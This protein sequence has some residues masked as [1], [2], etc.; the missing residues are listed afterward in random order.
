[1]EQ[2]PTTERTV[3]PVPAAILTLLVAGTNLAAQELQ[4]P[5]PFATPSTRNSASIIV[6]PEGASLRVPSGFAIE[7]YADNLPG[8]RTML[9]TPNGDILIAQRGPGTVTILRDTDGNRLPD[10]RY[11]YINDLPGVF[12]MAFH[13]GY[14]Y[15]GAN[16][17][18][19]RVPYEP[20]DTA[21]RGEP[22]HIVDMPTGGHSTRN[23]IF[24]R[25][26]TRMYVAVGSVSNK[27]AGEDEIRAA[28]S[29]YNPD[30]TG[31]RIYA[32]GLRNP[33]GLALQPGTNT[34]WT[35]VNERDT[36][37]DDL[38]PDYITSVRDGGFYGWPYSYI[39]SHPDP[40]HVG[41]ADELVARA[42]VP[43]V[44]LPAHAAA[45]SVTFYTGTAFPEHYLNGAFVGLHGSWNRS[46]PSGYKVVFVPFEGDM[47][48][49]EIEDFI[50]GWLDP[51]A[52]TTWGRPTSGLVLGDGSMLFSEDGNGTVWRVRYSER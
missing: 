26:G 39:G 33:V 11:T 43:D 12:G 2:L 4:L 47:P 9:E 18:I 44:L 7:L 46:I 40:E 41:K 28:I 6:R 52:P 5:E 29:E 13:E 32:S 15:L 38:V 17:R 42:V 14:L 21:A 45:V 50:T 10:E 48:T 22:E 16:D 3:N 34:I 31:H 1:M 51:G 24:S 30:G 37:G 36:L 19:V 20:G 23:L 35:S 49:G 27:S 8:A 25:D